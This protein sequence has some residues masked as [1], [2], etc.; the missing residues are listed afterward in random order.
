[1][2][3]AEPQSG[4]DHAIAVPGHRED[5][6]AHERVG[7][8]LIGVHLTRPVRILCSGVEHLSVSGLRITDV[9]RDEAV[10][11][12]PVRPEIEDLHLKAIRHG[13]DAVEEHEPLVEVG[14][15]V[16]FL[17]L[18]ELV[19]EGVAQAITAI[20]KRLDDGPH[21]DRDHHVQ[22]RVLRAGSLEAAEQ[23]G[24]PRLLHGA[25]EVGLGEAVGHARP[26]LHDL[27][28]FVERMETGMDEA[29]GGLLSHRLR[30]RRHD[31]RMLYQFLRVF[32][33]D[34][35]RE[36]TEEIVILAAIEPVQAGHDEPPR[37]PLAHHIQATARMG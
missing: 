11:A 20:E 33:A 7:N 21:I 5:V 24:V 25:N 6:S 4:Q 15:L 29:E 9:L 17:P 8:S 12:V 23:T 3:V 34:V 19:A 37:V 18:H 27:H 1:M 30:H 2:P 32:V 22:K 28:L 14:R 26:A 36:Q 13:L 31:R 10:L 16:G 35:L